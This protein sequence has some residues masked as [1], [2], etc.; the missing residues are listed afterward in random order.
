MPAK[1]GRNVPGPATTGR[2][3]PDKGLNAGRTT[4]DKG[5]KVDNG[6]KAVGQDAKGGRGPGGAS[7]GPAKGNAA[8]KL[9]KMPQVSAATRFHSQGVEH[10]CR[11]STE[12]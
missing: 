8:G 9:S 7:T 5:L 4:P 11:E 3:T 10:R 1:A 6:P 2:T 12:P